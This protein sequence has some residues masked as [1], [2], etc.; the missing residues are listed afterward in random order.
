MSC[1]HFILDYSNIQSSIAR[2]RQ[3][4]LDHFDE[5]NCNQIFYLNL[6]KMYASIQNQEEV[7]SL[8][9]VGI[10]FKSVFLLFN[11]DHLY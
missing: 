1:T 7:N 9:L 6:L 8:S 10:S 5:E 3:V 4:I 11:L 2:T